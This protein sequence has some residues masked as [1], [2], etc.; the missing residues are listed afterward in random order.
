VNVT[1][2]KPEEKFARIEN[3]CLAIPKAISMRIHFRLEKRNRKSRSG[4]RGGCFRN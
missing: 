3:Y 2:S 1:K 4:D